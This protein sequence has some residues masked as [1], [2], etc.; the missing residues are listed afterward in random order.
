MTKLESRVMGYI[1]CVMG[2]EFAYLDAPWLSLG[3]CLAGF[4]F[5]VWTIYKDCLEYFGGGGPGPL[6]PA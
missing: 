3:F 2:F 5:L 1:C 6:K 4:C